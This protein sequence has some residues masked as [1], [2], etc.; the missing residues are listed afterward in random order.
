[1]TA[2]R[3]EVMPKL[4]E[5]SAHAITPLQAPQVVVESSSGEYRAGQEMPYGAAMTGELNSQDL[6]RVLL[7]RWPGIA[8]RWR[9]RW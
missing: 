9:W 4:S 7:R 6:I 3:E 1:M 5:T 2:E 8:A